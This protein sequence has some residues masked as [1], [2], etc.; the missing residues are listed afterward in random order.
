MALELKEHGGF[1]RDW[2]SYVP[3]TDK[4]TTE[5]ANNKKRI[6]DALDRGLNHVI[7][8]CE[9]QKP[10]LLGEREKTRAKIAELCEFHKT[11]QSEIEWKERTGRVGGQENN[12]DGDEEV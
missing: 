3:E 7:E 5:L 9:A 4:N 1:V 8:A 2:V 12:D 6:D 11:R 10:V